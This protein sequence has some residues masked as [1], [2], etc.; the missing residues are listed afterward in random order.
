[1]SQLSSEDDEGVDKEEV[2]EISTTLHPLDEAMQKKIW[3][4]YEDGNL[5][6][7]EQ[8]LDDQPPSIHSSAEA[9]SNEIKM[10]TADAPNLLYPVEADSGAYKLS[11]QQRALVSA[12]KL[13][14]MKG[15]K[16]YYT[17]DNGPIINESICLV[18]LSFTI[19]LKGTVAH[20]RWSCPNK[21]NG[22]RV[23]SEV[24]ENPIKYTS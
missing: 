3:L 6:E 20:L 15:C 13:K 1:M 2:D 9:N 19:D 22:M 14:E 24:P 17:L 8:T 23:S 5:M 10:K 18:I 12:K 11:Q 7:L 21:H 4:V 16:C